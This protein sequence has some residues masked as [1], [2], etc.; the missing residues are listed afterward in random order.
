MGFTSVYR[1]KLSGESQ[2]MTSATASDW[3][4]NFALSDS[5]V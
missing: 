3:S 5:F 2:Y 4:S 1:Q